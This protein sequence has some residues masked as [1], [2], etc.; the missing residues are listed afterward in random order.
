[1]FTA[2]HIADFFADLR[3]PSF[4]SDFAVFHQR[5]STN[6]F[7]TWTL[8][9]PFRML[10]HNGEINTIRS[11][12]A[13]MAAREADAAAEVWGPR[14]AD[15]RPFL[16]PDR[17]DSASLDNAFE[18]LV[19][20]GRSLAH[21]KEMLVPAAWENVV[22]LEPELRAFYE[23]HAFLTEPWD[24][25]AAIAASD[26]VEVLAAVD[27]NGLRPARWMAN[28]DLVLVA[29]EAG[30]APEQ[31][32]R[33]VATGQLGPGEVLAVDLA[34]GALRHSAELKAGLAA[35]RPYREWISLET[36]YV[37]DPFDELQDFRFDPVRLSRVFGY[38]AE[39]RR[40]VLAE[41]AQGRLPVGS[42][43]ND[44]PLA[45]L[46]D[47]PP[48]LSRYFH[49]MFA[50]VTNPPVDPIRERLVMSLRTYLGRRG[51]LL[52]ET[53]EQAHL[54]ELASPVI[55]DAELSHLLGSPDPRFRSVTL[56][57]L[58]P[59][60]AGPEG[61]APALAGLCDAAAAAVAGGAAIVVLTDQGV[62]AERA[63]IPM[64]LAVGAVHHRLIDEGTRLHA[65]IVVASG[66][67]RDD[68]DVACLVAYGAS[69]VNPY[70]GIEQVR[71]MAAAEEIPVG[72]QMAQENYRRQLEEGLL[73]IMSKMGICTISAYRG[74]ELFEVIGLDAEVGDLAFRNT[75]RRVGGFGLSHLA[76]AVLARHARFD[77]GE[78]EG[79]GYY[80]H[81]R[82]GTVHVL[83]PR[84][85]LSLHE[86]VRSGREADWDDYLTRVRR[87]APAQLRDLMTFSARK[88][89]PLEEV[90]AEERIIRRFTS[91]AMS[92]GALSAEAHQ[93]VA[94][95]M[96]YLGGLANSGEGGQESDRL[97]TSRDPGIKQVASGRFGVTPWYL[98]SAED[99]QIKMAQG[100]KPGEG[101]QLP[102]R[103]VSADIARVRHT[104]P[105]VTLI[106]PP[107]HHDIYSIEDLAQLVSDL[108]TFRPS[109]RVSVKLASE[110]GIGVI[111]VGVAKAQADAVV[112]SGHEGG[113]GAAPLMSI[114]HAGAPWE[115]GLAEAHQ[116]LVESGIRGRVTLEVDGGLRTGRDVVVAALLGA[117]RFG[118]GTLPLLA[119]GCKMVRRCHLDTCPTGIATQRPELRA[120]FSGRPEQVET[121][122][123]LLAGEVRRHLAALGARSLEE[124]IGRSDLLRPVDSGHPV[125]RALDDLLVPFPGRAASSRFEPPAPSP[126][127]EALAWEAAALLAQGAPVSLE[128]Q[129]ENTDRAVGTRLAGII[130]AGYPAGLPEGTIR[131]R[132][133]G[134]A[135]Q[136]LGAFLVPGVHLHL[137]GAAN[138]GVGKGMAGGSIALAPR[139]VPGGSPP[140]AVGNAALYG[141][142]GGRLFA[143]GSAGLRFAVRNSGAEAVVEGCSDHGCEYMTGGAVVILGPTGRNLAAGMTGGVLYVW[144]PGGT[145]ARH[146]ATTSP[147][148]ARPSASDLGELQGLLEAHRAATGSGVAGELL[149]HWDAAREQ[150]WVLRPLPG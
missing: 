119:L 101:G 49:Q 73:K 72:V 114:K 86:A 150:F 92:L 85:V 133:T 56:E 5:Y 87:R 80:R 9:Q 127:G 148:A 31:E 78:E 117:D 118:F 35:R 41:M 109:A 63:P 44:T 24:G 6:T 77:G 67:P 82:G 50:Q 58:F 66:D 70:L 33:A 91:S 37:K 57:A 45:A 7:P 94:E 39:E 17:S 98:A 90:E 1:M 111:A 52:A 125:A 142:T 42:M 88:P 32:A 59:A 106:S 54:M 124:V 145:A 139:R 129:I 97:G 25:P 74:S 113:T 122:F 22:D 147:Q 121:L 116:T 115:V 36:L 19:R 81:Q 131:I 68:H 20:S 65:S 95:A 3:D 64:L 62:D 28:P 30:V 100:A 89:V 47:P 2:A 53:R 10:A 38:T 21:V 11:N 34:T 132:L 144:D 146:F 135:G 105:G 93:A 61:L 23:Y 4:V 112:I 55:S 96:S 143:A 99:L 110:P 27:R 137:A 14:T 123:R 16:G 140:H 130:A 71:A 134:T 126:L 83:S 141:A 79:G 12:R 120:R 18:L 46:A 48:R 8:A 60:S 29:S 76:S 102:G 13:W 103:K 128:Y 107:P 104:R 51:S 15:L 40:L 69:A 84:V 75:P 26:G 108:K 43:G 136:S 149:D 138:D